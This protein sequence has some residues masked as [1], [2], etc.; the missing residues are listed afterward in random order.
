M[1]PEKNEAIKTAQAAPLVPIKLISHKAKGML[2]A[3]PMIT[4]G[5]W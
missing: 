5:V 3:I 4:V 1:Y 2:M